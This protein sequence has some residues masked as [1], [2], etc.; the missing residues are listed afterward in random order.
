MNK[1][2]TSIRKYIPESKKIFDRIRSID[3]KGLGFGSLE[4]YN[5]TGITTKNFKSLEKIDNLN[6]KKINLIYGQNSAGKSS[7]LQSMLISRDNDRTLSFGGESIIPTLNF[8]GNTYDVGGF[9]HCIRDQNL[10]N[11]LTLG[12]EISHDKGFSQSINFAYKKEKFI[13]VNINFG[14]F[15]LKASEVSSRKGRPHIDQNF[16]FIIDGNLNFK[17]V[18]NNTVEAKMILSQLEEHKGLSGTKRDSKDESFYLLKCVNPDLLIHKSFEKSKKDIWVDYDCLYLRIPGNSKHIPKV[19]RI[20][21]G[22]IDICGVKNKKILIG[23]NLSGIG[24]SIFAAIDGRVFKNKKLKASKDANLDLILAA[25]I[26][27]L[28]LQS[29]VSLTHIPPIRGI[30]G[31]GSVA[32]NRIADPAVRY[33]DDVFSSSVSNNSNKNEIKQINKYLLNLGM[34]YKVDTSEFYQLGRKQNALVLKTLKTNAELGF[35]DVGKGVSQVLPI[36]VAASIENHEN[37]LIEQPEIHLHPKLQADVAE[38][39]VDSA[40]T[41]NNRFIVETHSENLLLRLQKKVRNKK[42]NCDDINIYYLK[43][44]AD[45][46]IN[47]IK[48]D[49][50]EDGSLSEDFPD[51]F[52]DIAVNEM[53]S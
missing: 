21:N 27:A 10:N 30:P 24:S 28:C 41:K 2:I 25:I 1:K 26:H 23:D 37:I 34:E 6:L 49:I 44:L 42:I 31:R 51:G 9:N 46:T 13:S 15:A 12:S 38:V 40:L 53:F 50:L 22:Y 19:P 35:A 3:S 16:T 52:F 43:K 32:N 47:P 18:S 33:M 36:I 4:K 17:V 29:A 11:T 14:F 39:L 20:L 8:L 5:L 48:I 45:G 7:F